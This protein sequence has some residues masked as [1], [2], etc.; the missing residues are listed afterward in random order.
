MRFYIM[1]FLAIFL[2]GCGKQAEPQNTNQV[3]SAVDKS[4]NLNDSSSQSNVVA[5]Q[6]VDAF[7]NKNEKELL[8]EALTVASSI[9]PDLAIKDRIKLYGKVVQNIEQI[10]DKHSSTDVG[11]TLK[12][13]NKFGD[14]DI[15]SLRNTYL[16]ESTNYYEKICDVTPSNICLG[17]TSLK[18]GMNLCDTGKDFRTIWK[19]HK[20][21]LNAYSIFKRL[22][23]SGGLPLIAKKRYFACTKSNTEYSVNET[24]DYFNFEL[25]KVLLNAGEKSSATGL[26]EQL[27]GA[28]YKFYSV[29]ELKKISGDV[30]DEAYVNRMKQFVNEKIS[31]DG[32]DRHSAMFVL[33]NLSLTSPNIRVGFNSLSEFAWDARVY[34]GKGAQSFKSKC[35][36]FEADALYEEAIKFA[37]NLYSLPVGGRSELNQKAQE[38]FLTKMSLRDNPLG[39]CTKLYTIGM[40]ATGR[41]LAAGQEV[42]AR[43]LHTKFMS[44]K[45][46]EDELGLVDLFLDYLLT[47]KTKINFI[48]KAVEGMDGNRLLPIEIKI[49]GVEKKN[50]N[51]I[52]YA[53]F[54]KLVDFDKICDAS[55]ILS[56]K[57]KGTKYQSEA[58]K[59]MSN[60][61]VMAKSKNIKCGDEDLELLLR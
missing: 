24:T 49:K 61:P 13:T 54:K 36:E 56:K 15:T 6:N 52:D 53:V 41:L 4:T 29:I 31:E 20:E 42:E 19:A 7:N 39:S 22:P 34:G 12:S 5:T 14:F 46:S 2:I 60:S 47:D 3:N 37:F 1:I 38:N 55:S 43:N 45:I 50:S 23:D 26:I 35:P 40:Y 9:S 28:F 27:N 25:I 16:N 17:F 8:S 51:S 58:I 59:Y 30:V 11:L 32:I 44:S 21:L 57:I 33:G 18:N 10:L 48:N